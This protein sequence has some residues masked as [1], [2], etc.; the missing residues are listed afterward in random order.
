MLPQSLKKNNDFKK[1]YKKGKKIVTK[2][3][4]FYY[5]KNHT[6]I[7]RIGF[8]VSKKIGNSVIRNRL[9]RRL[10]EVFRVKF[11]G[12]Q[13]GYDF[14]LVARNKLKYCNYKE[15][16]AEMNKTLK[17]FRGRVK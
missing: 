4:V 11:N 8:T 1:V 5:L 13:N 7:N 2:Y 6:E 12:N 9:K 16:E 3:F 14:V 10:R 15:L 17:K